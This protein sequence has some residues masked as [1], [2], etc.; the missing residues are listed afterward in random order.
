MDSMGVVHSNFDDMA[1]L[2]NIYF[3]SIFSA[4]PD[5]DAS[6]VLDLLEVKVLDQDNTHLCAP[7][8]DKEISDALFQIG[9]LKA[10]GLDGLPVIFFQRNWDVL[11]D[12]VIGTVKEFFIT[13]IMR[14]G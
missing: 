9:P 1:S 14:Q 12:N 4:E 6:L 7:F 5:L 13:G 10:P 11:K 3:Q 8:G 2:A